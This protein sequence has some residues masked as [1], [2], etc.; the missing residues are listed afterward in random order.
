MSPLPRVKFAAARAV[1]NIDPTHPYPGSSYLRDVLGYLSASGGER[2]VLIG[3]PRVD[4]AQQLAGF[5]N[6]LGFA[7]DSQQTGRQLALQAFT[8]P[9]YSLVLDPRRD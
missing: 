3:H 7:V 9:D 1:M 4:E 2:R 8:S 6:V 5:F